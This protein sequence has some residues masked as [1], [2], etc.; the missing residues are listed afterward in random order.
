VRVTQAGAAA[1]TLPQTRSA[2]TCRPDQPAWYYDTPDAP[3]KLLL[4]PAACAS[5]HR[6]NAKLEIVYGCETTVVPL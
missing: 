4:C 3:T 1:T 5:V 6:E 2:A